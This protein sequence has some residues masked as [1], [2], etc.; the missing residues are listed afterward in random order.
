MRREVKTSH[1]AQAPLSR[2]MTVQELA[3]LLQI[4]AKTIYAWR[5]KGEGPPGVSVG[6]HLRFRAED[7]AVWLDTQVGS[8]SARLRT[9][10]RR[11][12]GVE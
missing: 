9:R 10:Q 7:V 4:P 2:L 5:Y 11:R 8:P 6:R 1:T 3:D 12:G